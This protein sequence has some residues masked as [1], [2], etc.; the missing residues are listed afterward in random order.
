[1]TSH[2]CDRVR[3]GGVPVYPNT[4]PTEGREVPLRNERALLPVLARIIDLGQGPPGLVAWV[5]DQLRA[6][7]AAGG[8]EP[9]R[10][11]PLLLRL[12]R[13]LIGLLPPGGESGS[14][15]LHQTRRGCWAQTR[16]ANSDGAG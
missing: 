13:E 7:S 15:G 9:A 12:A 16:R 10:G 4:A 1:M 14:A 3:S 2:V 6:W 11:A 5:R 8:A